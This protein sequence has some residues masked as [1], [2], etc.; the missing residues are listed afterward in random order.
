MEDFAIMFAEKVGVLW[1]GKKDL[2]N[3][4]KSIREAV[5]RNL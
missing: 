2:L 3:K 4:R 5:D 1:R